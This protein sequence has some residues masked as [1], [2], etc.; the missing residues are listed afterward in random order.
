M[1]FKNDH[2]FFRCYADLVEFEFDYQDGE[3]ALPIDVRLLRDPHGYTVVAEYKTITA[4][5]YESG[6][7]ECL[8]D[9]NQYGNF[10]CGYSAQI[11]YN[12]IKKCSHVAQEFLNSLD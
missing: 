6:W 11:V 3:M 2:L 1:L 8:I 10:D 5:M 12:C 4:I 9:G 7:T